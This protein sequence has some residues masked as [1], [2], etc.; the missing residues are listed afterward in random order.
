MSKSVGLGVTH[1]RSFLKDTT[2]SSIFMFV[3]LLYSRV[4][5]KEM[6]QLFA[7]LNY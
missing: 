3:P 5:G 4:S 6:T 1:S 2:L 7:E